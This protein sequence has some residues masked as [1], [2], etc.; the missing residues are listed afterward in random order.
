[1]N[2]HLVGDELE[3]ACRAKLLSR[4]P[5]SEIIE[6]K[7]DSVHG[8]DFAVRLPCG[9]VGIM[10]VKSSSGSVHVDQMSPKWI[11]TRL[12]TKLQSALV[13]AFSRCRP[14]YLAT[15]RVSKV[16]DVFAVKNWYSGRPRLAPF[17]PWRQ[18]RFL[19]SYPVPFRPWRRL[20]FLSSYPIPFRPS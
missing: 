8:I 15:Y 9:G 19:S 13:D 17:R 3:K 16:G 20:R 6:A 2:W 11:A 5:N 7:Y 14:V 10:E 12:G 1:M 4:W 18:L